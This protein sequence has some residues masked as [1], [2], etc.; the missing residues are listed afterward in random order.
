M[1][2]HDE[3]PETPH[4]M[5]MPRD[6]HIDFR[7]RHQVKRRARGVNEVVDLADAAEKT[8]YRVLAGHVDQLT[9]GIQT[10]E[11]SLRRVHTGFT[12]GSQDHLGAAPRK[13]LRDSKPY[14]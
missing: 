2:R 8:G 12:V 7:N 11:F 9:A 3:N 1:L 14:S 13:K 5:I 6:F 4:V 10:I